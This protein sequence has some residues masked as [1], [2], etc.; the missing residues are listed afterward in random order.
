MTNEVPA[1]PAIRVA[2][3]A[4][5][6]SLSGLSRL[7]Y[8][9]GYEAG[10]K[11]K[12]YWR[13]WKNSGGGKFNSD[14]VALSTIT[15][16]MSKVPAGEAFKAA[17]LNPILVGRSVNTPSFIAAALVAEGLIV[18]SEKVARCYERG[19]A[20]MWWKEMLRLI[21]AKTN[22]IPAPTADTAGHEVKEEGKAK[23]P[24]KTRATPAAAHPVAK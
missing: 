16:V 11:D 21:E 2:K 18:R 8:H 19:N 14:W 12:I 13:I 5:C 15:V 10:S 6:D 23:S 22:L 9:V 24:K 1:I 17:A 3:I 7:E 20:D 4:T